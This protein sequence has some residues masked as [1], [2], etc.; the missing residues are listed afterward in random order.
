MKSRNRKDLVC[1]GSKP[2]KAL[3]LVLFLLGS[4]TM[5]A[6]NKERI[7]E[8]AIQQITKIKGVIV[9]KTKAP[10]P[11]VSIVIKGTA[12]GTITDINGNYSLDVSPQ[13]VIVVSYIGF[14]SQEILITGEKSQYDIVM[15]EDTENLDEVVVIGYGT[16]KKETV[17]GA[18]STVSSKEIV[19]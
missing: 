4:V 15:V 18:M 12:T 2:I 17:T 10:L 5:N 14:E 7:T 19:V 9:D 16:Q 8:D 13:S 11:G 6:S 1:L 3:L